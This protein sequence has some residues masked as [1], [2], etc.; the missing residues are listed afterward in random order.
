MTSAR[1]LVCFDVDSTLLAVESLDFALA[2]KLGPDARAKLD[3]ITNA[4]MGGQMSLKASLAARLDLARLTR[5][6][7][8]RIAVAL[9]S[10][11]TPG[12]SELVSSLRA[13]GDVVAAVSGGFHDLLR[14][15]LRDLGI[16]QALS[17]T[18]RFT[19]D[20]DMVSGFDAANPLSD[21]GGKAVV[22]RDLARTAGATETVMV[23]DGITDLEA[24]EAGAAQRFI[25][26]GGVIRRNAVA[27]RAPEYA[28]NVSDLSALLAN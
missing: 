18:N 17:Q 16:P 22:L 10:R 4:G 20:G 3:A 1:R 8:A 6:D 12:M 21:N 5:M 26:F 24:F 23:G 15:A 14:L 25:G 19:W 11:I 9:Q 7:A 28:A 2:E 13:K 27:A